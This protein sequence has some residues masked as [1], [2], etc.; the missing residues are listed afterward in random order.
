MLDNQYPK[1]F[2]Q[3]EVIFHAICSLPLG[4]GFGYGFLN[5]AKGYSN[6]NCVTGKEEHCMDFQAVV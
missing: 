6:E 3:F 1:C 4:E 2:N 5:T